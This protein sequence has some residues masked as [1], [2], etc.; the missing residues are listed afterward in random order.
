MPDSTRNRFKFPEFQ[1]C[2]S[3]DQELSLDKPPLKFPTSPA[4]PDLFWY[5]AFCD[6]NCAR[7]FTKHRHMRALQAIAGVWSLVPEAEEQDLLPETLQ[8]PK[9]PASDA[10]DPEAGR[11]PR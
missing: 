8:D 10:F 11:D 6:E 1:G 7:D 5:Y 3:C 2:F 4:E 9:H